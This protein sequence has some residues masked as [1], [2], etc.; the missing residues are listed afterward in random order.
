MNQKYKIDEILFSDH[1]NR[2][3]LPVC[4]H[5]AGNERFLTKALSIQQ[6]MGPAFDITI[7]LEDGSTISKEKELLDLASEVINSPQNEFGRIGIRI[8]G[9]QSQ[10][11]QQQLHHII[12]PN[13]TL[14]AYIT[15]PKVESLEQI[16]I[17]AAFIRHLE[18]ESNVS[19][20]TPLHIMVESPAAILNLDSWVKHNEVECVSFGLLD[21]VSAYSGL[22]PKTA[23]HSPMQFEHPLVREAKVRLSMSCHA[24]GKVASHSVTVDVENSQQAYEDARRARSEFAFNRMWSIH[25]SQIVPVIDGITPTTEEIDQAVDILLSAKSTGWAPVKYNGELHDRASYR[26]FWQQIKQVCNSG[27]SLPKRAETLL[28]SV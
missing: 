22:I 14:P 20:P 26:Y 16:Q 21:Y 11:W 5:Y 2:A 1:T 28:E 25:P 8:H 4:D 7:D 19:Q 27:R 24:Y 10:H 12:K 13:S 18:N 17:I 3:S 23:M 6:T 15:L 9:F